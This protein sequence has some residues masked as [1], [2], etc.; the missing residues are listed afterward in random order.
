MPRS[1]SRK[2]HKARARRSSA[3][4]TVQLVILRFLIQHVHRSVD[5]RVLGVGLE[6]FH[7]KLTP[8][9]FYNSI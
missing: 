8:K 4:R 7:L 9:H 3:G 2:K 1:Q 5:T 6:I